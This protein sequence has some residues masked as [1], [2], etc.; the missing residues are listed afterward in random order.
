MNAERRVDF[1]TALARDG[2]LD[3][4]AMFNSDKE[5]SMPLCV[6]SIPPCFRVP[7]SQIGARQG[8]CRKQEERYRR[9]ARTKQTLS[10]SRLV[11]RNRGHNY[12][13]KADKRGDW[14]ARQSFARV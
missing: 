11:P 4:A 8:I 1:K 12:R 5:L 9:L 14:P 3:A 6:E 10:M 13:L 7:K 2:A